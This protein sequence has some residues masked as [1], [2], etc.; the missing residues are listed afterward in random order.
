MNRKFRIIPIVALLLVGLLLGC[1]SDT[2]DDVPL[3]MDSV[4]EQIDSM[5]VS[6]FEE[7]DKTTLFVKLSVQDHGDIVLRLRPD[8]A[9]ISVENF[10]TLVGKGFYNGLTFHRVYPG[11]MIQGGDPDGN[12]GGGSGTNIK[13]EFASNGVENPL[14]HVRGVLSMARATKPN[15]ASSQFFIMHQTK[16]SLD[17]N[18]A[19]FGY[20]VAGLEV[21]DSICS[22]PIGYNAYG[23]LSQPLSPVIITSATFVTPRQ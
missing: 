17:G 23:E 18:Y 19:A 16:E 6:D 11:F 7:T 3:T 21:V 9:P 12:G 14:L 8:V 5:K 4:L 10:Q 2:P 20:V 13:G 15:T 22:V 1:S